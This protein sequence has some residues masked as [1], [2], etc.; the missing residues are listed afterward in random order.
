M[1]W[2]N[3]ALLVGAL[4]V[5]GCS[6]NDKKELP[7]A[8]LPK[9]E[10]EVSLKTQWSRSIGDGQGD[11]VYPWFG[12]G[13]RG[14]DSG[15]LASIVKVPCIHR[16]PIRR[17]GRGVKGKQG[18]RTNVFGRDGERHLPG[19]FPKF[20]DPVVSLINNIDIPLGV[21]RDPSRNIELAFPRAK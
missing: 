2:T 18:I 11:I 1:R 4:L 7:P 5:A 16:S 19:I 13:M 21:Y 14:D 6:S 8:E 3:A 10:R 15:S 9:F 12:I 17:T 20:L